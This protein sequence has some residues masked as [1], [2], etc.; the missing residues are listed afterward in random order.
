MNGQIEMAAAFDQR[1][2]GLTTYF[3]FD[4]HD[5]TEGAQA[6]LTENRGVLSSE[7]LCTIFVLG[8]TDDI[9]DEQYND[10]LSA[11]R[12]ATVVRFLESLGVSNTRIV[13]RH[14]G[15]QHPANGVN[16]PRNRRVELRA[17]DPYGK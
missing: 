4:K 1:I 11:R 13:K 9:G 15:E 5:L 7:P 14:F 10:A 12:A 16:R 2:R 8:H 17:V 6:A 3:E